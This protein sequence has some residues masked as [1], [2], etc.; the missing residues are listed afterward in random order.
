M[1][2]IG[3]AS[4]NISHIRREKVVSALNKALLPITADDSNFKEAAPALFGKDFAKQS[5]DLVD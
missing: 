3:N 4:S 5:K 2:L 1:E